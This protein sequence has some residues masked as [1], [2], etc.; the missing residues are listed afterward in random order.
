MSEFI[1]QL[2]KFNDPKVKSINVVLKNRKLEYARVHTPQE[3]Q[4]N[5]FFS[6]KVEFS[7]EE[8]QALK[9]LG[10]LSNKTTLVKVKDGDKVDEDGNPVMKTYRDSEGKTYL[11]L[12]KDFL[13]KEGNTRSVKVL[14][15]ELQPLP[16]TDLLGNGT[17][18]NVVVKLFRG[19]GDK[20]PFLSRSLEVIQVIKLV[21][22][23]FSEDKQQQDMIG[24][25]DSVPKDPSA[26]SDD[27]LLKEMDSF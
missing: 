24:L 26:T 1:E 21:K 9:G 8:F 23:E 16:K 22:P 7:V 11:S 4:N 5:K 20:G 15:S 17:V 14:D 18:A 27:K 3:Y 25:L 12:K 2:K 13:D 10:G 6:A 19:V